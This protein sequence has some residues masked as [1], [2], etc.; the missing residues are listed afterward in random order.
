VFAVIAGSAP[1]RPAAHAIA[2]RVVAVAVDAAPRLPSGYRPARSSL[3]RLA[4]D[5]V[6]APA[7]AARAPRRGG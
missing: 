7:D 5:A 4:P 6:A 2:P 3:R 1:A